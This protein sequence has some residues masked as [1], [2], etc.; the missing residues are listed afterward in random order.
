MKAFISDSVQ[1]DCIPPH[2]N[3]IWSVVQFSFVCMIDNIQLWYNFIYHVQGSMR[4]TKVIWMC[5]QKCIDTVWNTVCAVC[6][7]WVSC[8]TQTDPNVPPRQKWSKDWDVTVM[9]RVRQKIWHRENMEIVFFK[10]CANYS[11]W[12][13]AE[14]LWSFTAFVVSWPWNDQVN[15]EV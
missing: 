7:Q 15:W 14:Y 13:S 10:I 6:L 9:Q 11:I 12:I 2:D 4:L 3:A 8:M 1:T 5:P